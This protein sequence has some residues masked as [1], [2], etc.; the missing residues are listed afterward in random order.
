MRAITPVFLALAIVFALFGCASKQAAQ[1][2]ASRDGEYRRMLELQ[3][4]K[5]NMIADELAQKRLPELTAEDHDRLG[6]RFITQGDVSHAFLEYQKALGMKPGLASTRYKVG[7]LI[8]KEGHPEEALAQFEMIEKQDPGN[9][10]A[11]L[12]KGMVR[13]A[14]G[15]PAGARAEFEESLARNGKL[16][17]A[18]AY[19]GVILDR[20]DGRAARVHYKAALEQNPGSAVLYN[21]LGISYYLTHDYGQ[22]VDAYRRALSID[23]ANRRTWNNLGLALSKMGKY[24]DALESFKMARD[25]AGAYNNMGYLY[26]REHKY[27]EAAQALEKAIELRPSFYV[28]AHENMEMVTAGAKGG[29]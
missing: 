27:T 3:K 24:Q 14:K 18:H 8:L 1:P 10:L 26:L 15:D 5:T 20:Q 13:F 2:V 23:P 29:E 11:H 25:E 16:W 4:Q 7:R 12:G 21:N 28:K 6:D 19:L 22:A 9:A 17:Q